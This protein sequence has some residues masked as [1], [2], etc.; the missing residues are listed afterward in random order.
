M[1]RYNEEKWNEFLKRIGDGRSANDICKNDKD[2]PSWRIVSKKLNNDNEF[3]IKYATAKEVCAEVYFD[4]IVDV[5]MECLKG[6]VEPLPAKLA[7][8]NYKWIVS[9]MLPKKYGDMQRLEVVKGSTYID[10]LK[11]INL[12]DDDEMV[13]KDT[14]VSNELRVKEAE[15]EGKHLLN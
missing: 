6:N 14:T 3:A 9:K 2:M 15:E 5:S 10:A 11:T 7:S 1:P 4:K 8:D 13:Q 12:I